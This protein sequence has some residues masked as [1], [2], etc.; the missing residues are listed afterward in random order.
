MSDQPTLPGAK[1]EDLG[2]ACASKHMVNEVA[3]TVA[4]FGVTN[5]KLSA[6][7]RSFLSLDDS[8]TPDNQVHYYRQDAVLSACDG[9][10][11]TP[12]HNSKITVLTKQ[13][14]DDQLSAAV[15]AGNGQLA[16]YVPGM[17]NGP[18]EAAHDA[19]T[20]S[21]VTGE[22]FVVED[23]ASSDK[24]RS[25]WFGL[26]MFHQWDQDNHSSYLSQVMINDSV[27]DLVTK[28]GGNN[29]D[30]VSH[31][32]G[33]LNVSRALQALQA[34]GGEPVRSATFTHPEMERDDF[35]D[36]FPFMH[37][38]AQHMNILTDKSDDAA[39]IASLR[40]SYRD[41]DIDLP[42]AKIHTGTN[43]GTVG[44]DDKLEA[45]A[46]LYVPK[47]YFSNIREIGDGPYRHTPNLASLAGALAN[48]PSGYY[49]AGDGRRATASWLSSAVRS[50]ELSA[51]EQGGNLRLEDVASAS[52]E[53]ESQPPQLAM[54]VFGDKWQYRQ[55]E[56][57]TVLPTGSGH[58]IVAS[59]TWDMLKP[60]I[61]IDNLSLA[62]K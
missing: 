55:F 7:G 3:Q 43:L 11:L 18:G 36:A 60:K 41:G 59:K 57:Q 17:L 13:E 56:P 2:Q 62:E 32:R 23:W 58:A 42:Q 44:V 48:T 53:V 47:D 12:N 19:A 20:M 38:A 51:I 31:S 46:S 1:A 54:R 33:A 8:T 29:I 26:N 22:T 4:A 6:D 27:M 25:G 14:F 21:K 61:K 5:R 28:Y 9:V 30:L 24:S 16:I 40:R 10:R 15:K 39:W 45:V 37:S 35:A 52:P 50:N 49:S 34:V